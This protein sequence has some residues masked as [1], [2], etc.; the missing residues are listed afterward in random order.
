MRE[1]L[2]CAPE[3]GDFDFFTGDF[4]FFIGDFDFFTGDLTLPPFLAKIASV[5]KSLL[6]EEAIL[7]PREEASAKSSSFFIFIREDL[8]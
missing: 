1:A 3:A 5:M 6:L 7:T 4:D 8:V 2:V